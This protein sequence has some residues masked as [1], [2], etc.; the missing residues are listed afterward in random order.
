MKTKRLPFST[1]EI[2]SLIKE[3]DLS[4]KIARQTSQTRDSLVFKAYKV[5]VKNEL[6]NAEKLC[7]HEQIA[8]SQNGNVN[9]EIQNV[10]GK[11]FAVVSLER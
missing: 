3:R 9:T 8:L 6:R 11:S 2:R 7:V 1:P 4:H 5:K 10:F